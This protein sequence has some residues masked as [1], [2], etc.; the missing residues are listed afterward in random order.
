MTKEVSQTDILIRLANHHDIPHLI[1]LINMQAV[2]AMGWAPPPPEMPFANQY[3]LDLAAHGRIWVATEAP[4]QKPIGVI[5]WDLKHWPWN[6]KY[7]Y[8]EN[9]HFYVDK[10]HRKGGVANK[11]IQT[12]KDAADAMGLPAVLSIN[13]GDEANLEMKE[14]WVRQKGFGVR[15][16]GSYWYAG[17][18]ALQPDLF[19]EMV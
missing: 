19:E 10:R 9:I 16:G 11:L 17:Q 12:F 2:P 8:L 1:D 14:R 3:A 6:R 5:A 13:F 4:S 18:R 7:V 15:L